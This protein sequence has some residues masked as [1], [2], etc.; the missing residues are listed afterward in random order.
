MIGYRLNAELKLQLFHL[1][2]FQVCSEMWEYIPV[3]PGLRL[4]RKALIK[5]K[6]QVSQE[7]ESGQDIITINCDV[8]LMTF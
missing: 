5:C 2:V 3:L 1:L 8:S 7:I 4:F 6:C